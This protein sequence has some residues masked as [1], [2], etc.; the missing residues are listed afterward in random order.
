VFK[1]RTKYKHN[2]NTDVAMEVQKVLGNTDDGISLLVSW[3]NIKSK[4]QHK[5]VRYQAVVIK[6]V[7]IMNWLPLMS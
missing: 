6:N 3:W 7:E 5:I 2:N 4:I 1:V